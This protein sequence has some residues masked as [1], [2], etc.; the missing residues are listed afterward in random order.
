MT[1]NPL[2]TGGAQS[3][4]NEHVREI[5]KGRPEPGAPPQRERKN[6]RKR[7]PEADGVEESSAALDADKP[8]IDGV[9]ESGEE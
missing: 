5:I 4:T 9:E 8:E 2:P 6:F 1:K 7:K 3:V